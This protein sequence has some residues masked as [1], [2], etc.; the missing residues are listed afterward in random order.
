[1]RGKT[2][3]HQ[4]DVH[5]KLET[6]KL[7]DDVKMSVVRETLTELRDY[8][9]VNSQQLE[10]NYNMLRA[11]IRAYLN[12]NKCWIANDFRNDMK[13][14]DPME[15]DHIGKGTSKGKGNDKGKGKGKSKS[16]AK[17][18]GKDNGKGKDKGKSKRERRPTNQ[19]KS[20][21]CAAKKGASRET[22]GHEQTKTEQ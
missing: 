18:T 21:T 4:V 3:E 7:D 5:E 19:I 10:N 8:L 16:R 6:S 9:L 20:A 15:I 14:S 22:A 11:I 13:E 12:T 1:M 2:W 17:N